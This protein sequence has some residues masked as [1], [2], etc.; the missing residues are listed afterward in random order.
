MEKKAFKCQSFSKFFQLQMI[1][2]PRDPNFRPKYL[3]LNF[4]KDVLPLISTFS[5]FSGA[6]ESISMFQH[7]LIGSAPPPV[8]LSGD[9]EVP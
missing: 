2:A 8:P 6:S 1:V 3:L 7:I 5:G 4:L 9:L